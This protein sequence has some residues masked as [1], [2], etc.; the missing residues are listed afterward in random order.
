ME[1]AESLQTE[2]VPTALPGSYPSKQPKHP[3]TVVC[4]EDRPHY[5]TGV[6]L[7]LLSLAKHM[8]GVD[9]NVFLPNAS[10][11]F[12][13]WEHELEFVLHRDSPTSSDGFDIKPDLLKW[14]LRQ[15]Y[16]R[17]IFLDAD[18]VL[19]GKVP[20][21]LNDVDQTALI[22]AQASPLATL[23]T[24]LRTRY[25]GFPEGRAFLRNPSGCCISVNHDH[26]ELIDDWRELIH[27]PS[28]V[29]AQRQC[30]QHG[31]KPPVPL[32]GDDELLIALLGS[33]KYR[34]LNIHFLSSSRDIAQCGSSAA[35][36]VSSRILSFFRGLPP[37]VHAVARKPWLTSD[38][39]KLR[40]QTREPYVLVAR[41]YK[42]LL[43]ENPLWLEDCFFE[44]SSFGL[45]SANP[46][47]ADLT[48][49]IRESWARFGLRSSARTF[50][51]AIENFRNRR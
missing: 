27:S 1:C 26:L 47:L 49:A 25:W 8:P 41:Q 37:L 46:A 6:K 43:G 48:A 11:N 19:T 30:R 5:E 33:Q 42:D 13:N 34:D 32:R 29:E 35:F 44:C 3:I 23:P 21:V 14:G 9:V 18:I 45:F 51:Y 4:Y 2:L 28:Y 40:A 15:G 39:S 24:H 16:Q 7:L 22:V 38:L 36:P 12:L 20:Q 10:Q 50:T 31:V 17:V